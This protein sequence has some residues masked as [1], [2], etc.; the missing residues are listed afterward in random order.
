MAGRYALIVA[1]DEYE[2]PKLKRL[3][4]PVKDADA[5]ARVLGDPNLGGFEV[6]LVVNHPQHLLRRKV[7]RFLAGRRPDDTLLLHFSCHG[8]KDDSGELFFAT[9]DTEVDHLEDSALE[10]A[11]VRRRMDTSLSRRIIVLLD[12]CFSGALTAGM[13]SRAGDAV[14]PIE[15]VEGTGRVVLTSSGALEYAWEGDTLRGEAMPSVFTS[16]IVAGIETGEADRDGDSWVS[17]GELYEFV[18]EWILD[19]GAKQTPG[20]SGEDRCDRRVTR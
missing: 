17:I 6:D 15:H 19:S 5:L 12:C 14:H 18:Y 13:R 9:T 20:R 11:W 10:S 7:N 1:N 8:L 2:D 3:R 16:A 4:G